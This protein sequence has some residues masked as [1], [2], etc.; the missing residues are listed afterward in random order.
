[1]SVNRLGSLPQLARDPKMTRRDAE[2]VCLIDIIYIEMDTKVC[3]LRISS[4]VS[5]FR[6]SFELSVRCLF[7]AFAILRVWRAAMATLDLWLLNRRGLK[8]GS[9]RG[10]FRRCGLGV[11]RF[12]DE[13]GSTHDWKRSDTDY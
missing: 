13:C 4:F 6:K 8:L 7:L 5:L 1:M 9:G 2:R 12:I 10:A 11:V 3:V